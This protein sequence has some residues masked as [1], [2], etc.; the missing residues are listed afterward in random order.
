M[1]VKDPRYDRPIWNSGCAASMCIVFAALLIEACAL[2]SKA[3][4]GLQ[5]ACGLVFLAQAAALQRSMRPYRAGPGHMMGLAR[6]GRRI[7]GIPSADL[8][9][10]LFLAALGYAGTAW[11][12]TGWAL[13]AAMFA[14]LLCVLPWA[15]IPLCR[16]RLPLAGA[17]LLL[18]GVAALLVGPPVRA[19]LLLLVPAWM[20]WLAASSA[21]L[22]LILLKHRKSRALSGYPASR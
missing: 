2:Q 1:N 11:L 5:L 8:A 21:W 6:G 17:L 7:A 16:Q 19:P 22:R 20:L 13:S 3:R 12:M 14:L 15:R 10:A 9:S 18:G 4:P